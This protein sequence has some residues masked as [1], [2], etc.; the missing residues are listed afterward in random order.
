MGVIAKKFFAFIFILPLLLSCTTHY[1]ATWQNHDPD[2]FITDDGNYAVRN[3]TIGI[4]H[5]FNSPSGRV[6]IR[7]ENYSDQPIL[8]NLTKSAMTING[9]TFNYVDGK[10][11]IFG[12]LNQFGNPEFGS[13]G[14]FRGE[15]SSKTNTLIIPPLSFAESEFTDIITETQN[16]LGENVD[17]EWTNYPLFNYPI[18]TKA[19]FYDME[20]SPM[21]LTSYLNYSVLDANNQPVKTGIITQNFHLSTYAKLRNQSRQQLNHDLASRDDMSS[22]AITKGANTGLTLGL[23][24]ILALAVVVGPAE[25]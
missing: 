8:V 18:H 10:S 5:A 20:N 16:I 7:M 13:L 14:I 23:L 4:S 1:I 12:T 15:I 21:N 24:G 2:S 22:F 3:D 17:G 25:E 6:L 11:T 9:R 19:A